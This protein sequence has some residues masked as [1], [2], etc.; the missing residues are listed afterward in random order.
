[1]NTDGGFVILY[2]RLWD[3]PVFRDRVEAAVFAWM[4]CA[5]AWRRH[6]VR[7]KGRL[8][9]LERGQ[10]AI[11]VRD[12]GNDWSWSKDR[13]ARYIERLR[14]ET[15]IATDTATGVFVVTICKYDEYQPTQVADK[16]PSATAAATKS[17]RQI[18]TQPRQHH[19]TEIIR[20]EG[21]S[22]KREN[23]DRA[24]TSAKPI[25]L[26]GDREDLAYEALDR[27]LVTP[28]WSFRKFIDE[29]PPAAGIS[30]A[31]IGRVRDG[32]SVPEAKRLAVLSTAL[33]LATE[34]NII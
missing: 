27:L 11:S 12:L 19:D 34:E 4:V 25:R 2:R 30:T 29:C 18:A 23:A 9:T 13:T 31:H 33:R 5:A 32:Q 28:G 14:S 24:R 17:P 21:E 26:S 3:N 1:M 20:E 15:M 7:Y 8:I 6:Q 22:G 16:T 10:L